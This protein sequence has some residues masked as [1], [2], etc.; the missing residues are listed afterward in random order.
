MG[1]RK[2]KPLQTAIYCSAIAAVAL[3]AC[4]YGLAHSPGG[5]ATTGE[6]L[7]ALSPLAIASLCFALL[8]LQASRLEGARRAFEEELGGAREVSGLRL[9]A[10]ESLAIAID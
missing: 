2:S 7:F 6:L 1:H 3:S 9:K 5:G 4:A 10:V 8:R